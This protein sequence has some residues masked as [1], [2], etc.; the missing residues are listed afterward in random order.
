VG[1]V[2]DMALAGFKDGNNRAFPLQETLPLKGTLP[3]RAY[4]K[5]KI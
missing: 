1:A 3:H 4:T 2:W 5:P